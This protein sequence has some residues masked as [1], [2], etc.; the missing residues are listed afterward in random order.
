MRSYIALAAAAALLSACA[1][2]RST[3]DKT[4][5]RGSIGTTALTELT[6][7]IWVDPTGC[8]HW[9]IDD[10]VEGYLTPRFD[11]RTRRPVCDRNTAPPTYVTGPYQAGADI[12]DPT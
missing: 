1:E 8:E 12:D 7:G 3:P 10:G 11:P 2:G 6:P 9:L 5:D 4:V